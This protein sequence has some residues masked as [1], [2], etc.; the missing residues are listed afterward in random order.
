MIT[1]LRFAQAGGSGVAKPTRDAKPRART[2]TRDREKTRKPFTVDGVTYRATKGGNPTCP[3][4]CAEDGHKNEQA[5]KEAWCCKSH[6][7]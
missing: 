1:V 2:V 4:K 6:A 5:R 7:A 3:V